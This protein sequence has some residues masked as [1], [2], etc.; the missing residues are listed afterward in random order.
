DQSGWPLRQ[1]IMDDFIHVVD[2]A[3]FVAG[4]L[5]LN[6]SYARTGLTA[7]QLTA[8]GQGAL[9]QLSQSYGAGAATE[10]LE[11]HGDGLSVIVEDMER[12]RIRE[13]GSER[14]EA[15]G[16]SWT[17]TLEKKGMAGATEHFL[18]CLLTGTQPETTAAEAYRTQEL[19]EAILLGGAG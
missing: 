18:H 1:I 8:A 5:R 17:S 11:L 16:G 12:L 15:V 10:V 4:D 9:V 3:R 13:G 19:A 6:A 2:T 7:A 14:L